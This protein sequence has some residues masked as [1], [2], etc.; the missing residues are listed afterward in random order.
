MNIAIDMSPLTSGNF[1]Q[2]RVRGTGIYLQNLKNSLLKYSPENNYYFFNRG[3][4]IPTT[5]DLVHYPYFEPFFL[6][7]PIQKKYKT[8]VT[9]HDLTPFVFPD[10]FPSGIK[11]K[12]KWNMQR[13]LLRKADRI[14]TDSECSKKDVMKYTGIKGEKIQVVYLAADE[15][16]RKLHDE[17][18]MSAVKK[19]YN[20]PQT[21]G[22]YV[23][24]VTWNKNLPRLIKAAIQADISLVMVGKTLTNKKYDAS[25]KWNQDLRKTQ[26][27]IDSCKNIHPLGF[28]P[29]EELAAVYNCATFFAMPSL[30]EGFGLPL[31]EAMSCGCPVVTSKEGSIPEVVG[32]A[33]LYVDAYSEKDIEE[34]MLKIIHNKALRT[35]LI[36]K[37]F[38][39]SKKFSWEKTAARMQ[40]IYTEVLKS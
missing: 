11:G 7:L 30:Y 1:L 20:L 2:H 17:L 32:D 34:G 8:V 24:D 26:E 35:G 39:R 3:D 38:E 19:K 6:T 33:G 13:F 25:N 28:I 15:S 12:I 40:D 14:V 36:K 29:T 18:F 22:L 10:F 9:V 27:L 21:F 23:G 4:A 16:Y 37:G 5:I 31:L